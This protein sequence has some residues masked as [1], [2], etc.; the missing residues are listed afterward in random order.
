MSTRSTGA[1]SVAPGSA[2]QRSFPRMAGTLGAAGLA[3]PALPG[4]ALSGP[5]PIAQARTTTAPTRSRAGATPLNH[6]VVACQENRTFDHYFGYYPRAGSFGVPAA[7][8]QPDGRGNMVTPYHLTSPFAGGSSEPAHEWRIIH[9]EYDD[10]KMDGFYTANGR[11]ALGYYDARD[12]AY[13]YALADNFTLCGNFF[14]S[15]LGPTVPNR[16]YLLAGTAGGATS[17]NVPRGSL[18]YPTLLD[19]LDEA[20]VSWKIY[21]GFGGGTAGFNPASYFA[22][23]RR[24]PRANV[25]DDVYFGDLSNGTLPHVSFIVPNVFSCEHPP[26]S[27]EWGQSYIQRRVQALMDSTAWQSAAFILTYDEGGGFFDHVAPPRV[28]AYGP[29]LRVPTLIVSPYARRGY[30]S[31]T[32]YDHGSIL[33]LVESVFGLPTLASVNHEFD[34][35]TPGQNNDAANGAAFGPP[36]PPRDGATVTGNLLDAFDVGQ[37]ASAR[38]A[39]PAASITERLTRERADNILAAIHKR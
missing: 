20:G 37:G 15:L 5:A 28:D 11:V 38:P 33:K 39:L 22:K 21:N 12:L 23:W 19:L 18:T 24:D 36:A 13:Y 9:Q 34:A 10:G 32:V 35:R 25:D 8:A 4:V 6:I 29:G 7:Y 3:G 16:I 2:S 30:I 31:P 27:V 17:N 14:C 1:P 26:A